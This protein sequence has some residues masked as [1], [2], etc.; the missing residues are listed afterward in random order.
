MKEFDD[1]SSEKCI[2][3]LS[4]YLNNKHKNEVLASASKNGNLFFQIAYLFRNL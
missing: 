2:E 1:I 3:L 4:T